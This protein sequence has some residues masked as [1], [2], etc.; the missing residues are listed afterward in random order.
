MDFYLDP[1]VELMGLVLLALLLCSF[2]LEDQQRLLRHQ[3]GTWTLFYNISLVM[4]TNF[5]TMVPSGNSCNFCIKYIYSQL[6]WSLYARRRGFCYLGMW[7]DTTSFA[8]SENTIS[9]SY[10]R[11]DVRNTCTGY[12]PNTIRNRTSWKFVHLGLS[13]DWDFKESNMVSQ[14]D[15]FTSQLY[16][17][18]L[19]QDLSLCPVR[20]LK[21]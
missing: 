11:S 18:C 16:I 15:N 9:A 4:H 14:T 1:K 12:W 10:S 8:H 17:Q 2:K 5:G 20:G 19:A 7:V 13:W 6:I 21:I 3:R